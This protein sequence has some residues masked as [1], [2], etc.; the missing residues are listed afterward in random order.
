MTSGPSFE[1]GSGTSGAL[2]AGTDSSGEA[3]ALPSTADPWAYLRGLGTVLSANLGVIG[4]GF[5]NNVI[6]ARALGPTGRGQYAVLMTAVLF[7]TLVLGEGLRLANVRELGRDRAGA[8]ALLANGL[9]YATLIGGVL[10][11]GVWLARGPLL[12]FLTGVET[13]HLGTAA[14]IAVLALMSQ[15]TQSILHGL[16]AFTAYALVPLTWTAVALAGNAV[17]LYGLG[18]GLTAV[19]L[20]WALATAAGLCLGLVILRRRIVSPQGF[21]W[22]TLRTALPV[23]SRATSGNILLFALRRLDLLVVNRLVGT[24][25]AGVYSIA[26][27]FAQFAQMF[28]NYAG[29][30]LFPMASRGGGGQADLLTACIARMLLS[31]ALLG[32]IGFALVGRPVIAAFFGPSFA[33]AYVP[34]VAMLPGVAA[35]AWG[36]ILNTNLWG[37]G[38]PAVAVWA[39][40]VAVGFNLALNVLLVPLWGLAAAGAVASVT[41]LLWAALIARA[42]IRASGVGIG[43]LVRP[44]L[45]DWRRGNDNR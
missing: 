11:A 22:R 18:A 6:L 43:V 37:R 26:V 19:M 31:L 36:S 8:K 1:G 32:G 34:L 29:Q 35:F 9:V 27:V 3:A 39:P 45:S 16:E 41:A 24:G 14:G 30:V 7:T 5:A 13:W 20:V 17:V 23:A 4:L 38:Y 44:R 15:Q 33:G 40:A 12:G 42:F 2:Q 10:V 25:L 21:S 28:A